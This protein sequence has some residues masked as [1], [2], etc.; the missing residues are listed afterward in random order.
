MKYIYLILIFLLTLSP[1]FSQSKKAFSVNGYIQDK[2]SS[3]KLI[4]CYVF[5]SASKRGVLTNSFGYFN[6]ILN[7]GN[8]KVIAHF[9]G[10]ADQT[11]G[12][13]IKKDT[14]IIIKLTT[15]QPVKIDEVTVVSSNSEA[16]LSHPQMS[17]MNLTSKDVKKLPVLLGEADVMRAIQ[18][19]P[20]IQ[21]ANERSS[22]ISVRGGSI[23]QNLFL[24]DDA[25]VFQISHM[26]GFFSVFNNDAVKDIKIYKGDIPANYGGRL[27]SLV[28]IRLKDGNMQ[29]YAFAG[30]IGTMCSDLSI[31]GP[32]IK[33]RVSFII[34]GKDAYLGWLYKHLNPNVDL[35]FYDLNCKL[36][37]VINSK[38]RIYISL[39]NGNDNTSIGMSSVYRNNTLSTRWNHVYSPKLF[40]NV[41]LI[42][43]NFGYTT[44]Y[45]NTNGINPF[46]YTWSSGIKQMTLKAEYNYY[47][48]NNNTIDFGASTGYRDFVPGK[49]TGN[50]TTI[51]NIAKSDSFSNRVV[52]EQ[53]VLDHAV[54]ISNQQRI[55][56]KL[57]FKYGIRAS[58]YQD[59]GGHWV[60][61]LNNYQVADSFYAA[62]NKPYTNY[63][64][65]E[66]RIGI[67][68]RVS[69]NSAFKASYT[70]ATQQDQLLMKTN[71]GGPLD[72]WFPSDNNIKP[73]TSSQY[74]VGY[75][76][77]LFNN[78]LEASIESYYKNMD[79]I[80]E[81]KDGA[82]FLARGTLYQID[83]T[84]YNFE[85]QLRTGIGYAYGTELMLKSGFDKLNG[86]VSYTYARSFRKI[87][88]INFGQTY[89]SPFDKPN[90]FDM[91]LNFNI[92]KRLS[93]S[94]NFRCQSGQV[95]TVP[96]YVMELWG[97]TLSGYSNRNGYR[98]PTYQRLDVSLTI[99]NKQTPGKR[100]HS[101]WNFSIIN[102]LNHANI[103]SVEFVPSA[104][105]SSIIDAKGI[106][107]LPI[108][109]S[110]S[111]HF[112]F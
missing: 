51:N 92:T 59:L 21:A 68:Y 38:G 9:F 23:D 96:I 25:P 20:G 105:N 89:L 18:T 31:E 16:K 49:L 8:N 35:T 73:Q 58:L 74:S 66:P 45:K 112:N 27:S 91:F 85:E 63:F 24:L 83:K 60:Y 84:S 53:Q 111:Y 22:G 87:P 37:A 29:S 57:S 70:Y 67:N 64:S 99:K 2:E 80:I 32:I 102:V 55:T 52:N 82:T 47:L 107:L 98:L 4:G 100:F 19:M 62:K 106:S 48:D 3:E 46:N 72:I 90:T 75:V 30:G 95:T 78:L 93:F 65:I 5:D 56:D 1:V 94:T 81:Y 41:S 43:S 88:D 39:Y 17:Q 11:I 14:T 79:N 104:G 50:Q 36:N 15:V 97:K 34:S 12:L 54:Y 109:P 103:A 10:Y 6:I 33:D 13:S 26:M 69:Q 28:D 7:E 101:E 108:I 86:F 61:K 110:V 42:Y 44:G 77:Y 76:H 71:G 40:S